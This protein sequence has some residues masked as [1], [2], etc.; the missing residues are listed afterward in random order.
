MEDRFLPLLAQLLLQVT[1]MRD[2]TRMAM[3]THEAGPS[4]QSP[5]HPAVPGLSNAALLT[6]A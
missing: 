3:S 2:T 4:I 6:L 1:L 5:V